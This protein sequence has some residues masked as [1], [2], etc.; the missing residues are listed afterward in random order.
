MSR[1]RPE[2][3]AEAD[4]CGPRRQR[5]RRASMFRVVVSAAAAEWACFLQAWLSPYV[6]NS[7]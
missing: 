1:C 7:R 3:E 5:Q 4:C 6:R 2:E